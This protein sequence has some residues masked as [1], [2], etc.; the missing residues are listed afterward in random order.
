MPDEQPLIVN[1]AGKPARAALETNCP[2]CRA[3]KTKRVL[4][5]SFGPDIH[6]VCSVCGH[7]FPERTIW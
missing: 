6:D 7:D 2:N 5:A 3:P 4:S 1:P